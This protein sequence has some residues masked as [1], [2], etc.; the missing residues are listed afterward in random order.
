MNRHDN[1]AI[2]KINGLAFASPKFGGDAGHCLPVPTSSYLSIHKVLLYC[3]LM[4]DFGRDQPVLS[5][6][7]LLFRLI[8]SEQKPLSLFRFIYNP[9]SLLTR[10]CFMSLVLRSESKVCLAVYFSHPFFRG[11]GYIRALKLGSSTRCRAYSSP[12]TVIIPQCFSFVLWITL[13]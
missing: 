4:P 1:I 3:F 5:P 7:R 8:S 10:Y 12:Y 11:Q 6:V 9:Q 2:L 13:D